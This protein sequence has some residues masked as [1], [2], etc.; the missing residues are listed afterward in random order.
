[1]LSEL[2][3]LAVGNLNRARARLAMT[4]GGVLVGTTA[5]ILL[6]ALTAG[7]QKAAEASIG[8][9]TQLTE[10]EVYPNYGLLPNGQTPENIPTLSVKAVNEFWG[11]AGVA[12]VIPITNLQSGEIN[13]GKYSGYTSILGIDA[14]LLPY[15]GVGVQKGKLTLEKDTVLLG[16]QAGDYFYDPKASGDQ[17][18]TVPV[19][20]FTTPFKIKLYQYNSQTPNERKI[21]PK[22]AGVLELNDRFNASMLMPIQDVIAY[23]EWITGNKFDAK[24]F[25]FDQVIVRASSRETVTSISEKLKEMGYMPQGLA[26]YVNQLN[27]FFSAMRL[28]LGGV[29]GIALLVAAFGVANT[30]TMAIL[31][32][33][34]EI[35]LMKAIG[36]TDRDVLTVFLVEAGLVGLTGGLAGVGLSYFLQNLINQAVAQAATNTDPSQP[37][38]IGNFLPFDTSRIGGQLFVIQPEVALFALVLAAAVGLGA[39]LYPAL[40]AARLPPVIALKSE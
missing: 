33:T 4:A 18:E 21:G 34:K 37:G 7:L 3:V 35:G 2:A 6:V 1:M 25:V 30:M 23:N 27:N 12:A 14:Q 31:E 29:G 9:S 20:L 36:A 10:L 11:I 38:G 13:A 40:R 24:K 22:P 39:G 28:I 15:L 8:S 26:E 19:D 5:V 17:Y 32:R 16:A